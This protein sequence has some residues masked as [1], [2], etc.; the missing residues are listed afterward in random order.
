MRGDGRDDDDAADKA[1]HGQVSPVNN[2]THRIF[3]SMV[4]IR[5]EASKLTAD[6]RDRLVEWGA[7]RAGV[8]HRGVLVP[9][10]HAAEEDQPVRGWQDL[11]DRLANLRP[12]HL[13]AT[14]QP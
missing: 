4:L 8:T 6:E 2:A 11:R 10:R 14:V 3:D 13:Q 12:R 1:G 7:P 9:D 5:R